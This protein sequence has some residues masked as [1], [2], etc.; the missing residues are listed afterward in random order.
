VIALPD[1][2]ELLEQAVAAAIGAGDRY[3]IGGRKTSRNRLNA[4]LEDL[5]SAQWPV[6]LVHGRLRTT[7]LVELARQH[8]SIPE[9]LSQAGITT[10]GALDRIL[11][12]IDESDHRAAAE[13]DDDADA[14][15][16]ADDHDKEHDKEHEEDVEEHD[17]EHDKHDQY[18]EDEVEDD[19]RWGMAS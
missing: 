8:H 7:Y 13:A 5:G 16:D 4:V 2:V 11:P 1:Y 6:P 3:L 10:L 12:F 19:R 9:L 18:V 17:K 15:A 14:D